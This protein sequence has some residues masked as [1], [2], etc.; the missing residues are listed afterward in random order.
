LTVLCYFCQLL[1]FHRKRN[2]DEHLISQVVEKRREIKKS[3]EE[4]LSEQQK[5]EKEASRAYERWLYRKVFTQI[6]AVCI[7]NLF[8]FSALVFVNAVD[9]ALVQFLVILIWGI[10]GERRR[11]LPK[12]FKW[13]GKSLPKTSSRQCWMVPFLATFATYV[14]VR[15]SVYRLSVCLSFFCL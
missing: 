15:R 13:S 1:C 10:S 7:A 14:I 9:S 3:K 6:C 4:E 11:I 5:R 12:L 8:Q 2:K